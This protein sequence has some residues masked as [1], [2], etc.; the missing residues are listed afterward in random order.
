M[1]K[2][3]L[4]S[5]KDAAASSAQNP[6]HIVFGG[7]ISRA[8]VA[9]LGVLMA[10]RQRGL[11]FASVGGISAG[12]VMPLLDAAGVSIEEMTKLVMR[13]NL[14]DFLHQ[15]YSRFHLPR[16]IWRVINSR[17]YERTLPSNGLYSTEKL[18]DFIESYVKEWPEKYWTM[19]YTPN[20]DAQIIFTKYGVFKRSRDGKVELVDKT[21][22]PI[23]LAIRAT[24]AVPGFFDSVKYTTSSGQSYDLF[25]GFISWDGYC[26]AALVESF[27]GAQRQSIIA[28]DVIK[29]KTPNRLLDKGYLAVLTPNPP[30]PAHRFEP[31]A[32]Q[33]SAG[34]S[35]A[36]SDAQAAFAKFAPA[37]A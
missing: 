14:S 19:A 13:H 36:F 23:G 9:D 10:A 33:K 11:S 21:P 32:A 24:G 35:Q 12:A 29:Y 2:N 4:P 1:I 28:C 20:G 37:A 5:I 16:L 17:R 26:P 7:G 27:F 6:P 30:F 18:A 8:L 22:A 31:S 3:T 15:N 25:D 34:V